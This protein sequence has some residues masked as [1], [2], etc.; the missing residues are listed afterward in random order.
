MTIDMELAILAVFLCAC[1]TLVMQLVMRMMVAADRRRPPLP[2]RAIGSV[3]T[4][5]G[6]LPVSL[7]A[8]QVHGIEADWPEKCIFFIFRGSCEP[9]DQLRPEAIA[10]ARS[11]RDFVFFVDGWQDVD[12]TPRN[13][14]SVPAGLFS[15][16]LGISVSPAMVVVV[17]GVIRAVALVNVGGQI[18]AVLRAND[19][20]KGDHA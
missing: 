19:R 3:I 18:E 8:A 11:Y 17:Q 15:K 10:A 16:T 7:G 13:I 9:C 5:G 1:L 12:G 20:R 2:A 6:T 14:W 4:V